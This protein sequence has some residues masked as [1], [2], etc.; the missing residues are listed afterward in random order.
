MKYRTEPNRPAPHGAGPLAF[1]NQAGFPQSRFWRAVDSLSLAVKLALAAISA[2]L[3]WIIEDLADRFDWDTTIFGD[4]AWPSHLVAAIFGILVMAPYAA[5]SSVRLL[6][7][8][9]MCVASAFIYFYA[10]KFVIEGP[11]SYNT[12]APYLISGGSAALLVGLSVAMF[13]P[14]RASWR[15]FVLCSIAGFIGGASFDET[16]WPGADFE[17]FGGHVIWQVLVCLALHFGL[18][19]APA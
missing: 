19:P 5:V 17:L 6:R 18:R 10:V 13:A 14:R 9:G 7:V 2:G 8:L 3:F 4:F 1:E 11:L 16:V 15:L 12:P